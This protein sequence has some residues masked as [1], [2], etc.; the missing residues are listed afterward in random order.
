MSEKTDA[1][2]NHILEGMPRRSIEC[3]NKNGFHKFQIEWLVNTESS[4]P[5]SSRLLGNKIVNFFIFVSEIMI[6]ELLATLPE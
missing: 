5:L 4:R 1:I 6:L 2:K 3:L